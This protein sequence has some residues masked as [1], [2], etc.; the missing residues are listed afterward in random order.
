RGGCRRYGRY[1][2]SGCS[3]PGQCAGVGS[4]CDQRPSMQVTELTGGTFPLRAIASRCTGGRPRELLEELL[5]SGLPQDAAH[6]VSRPVLGPHSLIEAVHGRHRIVP[7]HDR[8]AHAAGGVRVGGVDLLPVVA[9]PLRF[10]GA[11]SPPAQADLELVL[12]QR[13]ATC[14]IF[15]TW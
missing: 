10:E 12:P 11:H 6:P 15:A 9:D 14:C 3:Y 4:S 5:T 2:V 13:T 7:A 8:G 1:G